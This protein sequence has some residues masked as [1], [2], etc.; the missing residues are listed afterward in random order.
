MEL[1]LPCPL[2]AGWDLVRTIALPRQGADGRPLGGFSAAAYQPEL[3]RLWLLSDASR[4][5]LLPLGR[6]ARVLNDRSAALRPGPRLLLRDAGGQPLPN[7]IDAEG[8]VLEGSSAWIISEGRR[9]PGRTAR[10]IRIEMST[11]RQQEVLQLPSPWRATPG[12]GLATNQGPESLTALA[13]SQLLLAAERPLLQSDDP[14]SIPMARLGRDRVVREQGA[15]QIRGLARSEGLTELLALPSQQ[16]LLALVRGFQPPMHWTARLLLFA[17]PGRNAAPP[18]EPLHGWDLLQTG[19]ASDN[20]EALAVGPRLRDGRV[21]LILGSDDNFN[22]LQ[23]SW[24]A[25]LAPRRTDACLDSPPPK[26]R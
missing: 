3:D 19:L 8:L 9:T 24:I 5:H 20:W 25:V 1:S 15:L 16:R 21:T 14:A 13:P 11:G 17:Y 10:L 4:G 7:G 22:P 2:H 12:R 23:S 6:L 26:K 18:L